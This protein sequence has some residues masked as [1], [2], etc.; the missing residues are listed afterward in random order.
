VRWLVVLALAGC[1]APPITSDWE[2]QQGPKL[3]EEQAAPLPPFPEPRNLVG[4]DLAAPSDMR[5]FIDASSLWV[6]EG[7]VRYVMVATSPQGAQNVSYE[8]L[9][10]T[11]QY[12]LLA[13]GRA[14]GS[15]SAHSGGWR[16]IPRLD[17]SVQYALA[18][19]YFCPR[20]IPVHTAREA[21]EALRAGG[22]GF[23]KQY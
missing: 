19:D 16:D 17:R 2:R 10:C 5:Y 12:R 15:W 11:G 3:A 7:V 20:R 6:K 13:L 1:G 18:R 22:H 8:A 4:F 23:L 14:D 21:V 9:R